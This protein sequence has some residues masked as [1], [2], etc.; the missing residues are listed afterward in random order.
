M[1]VTVTCVPTPASSSTRCETKR[2]VWPSR[3]SS[4]QYT[5]AGALGSTSPRH[6]R[7]WRRSDMQPPRRSMRKARYESARTS[8]PPSRSDE[9]SR[10]RGCELQ[11]YSERRFDQRPEKTK[12]VGRSRENPSSGRRPYL[13]ASSPSFFYRP[14]ANDCLVKPAGTWKIESSNVARRASVIVIVSVRPRASTVRVRIGMPVKPRSG[15][16]TPVI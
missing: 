7:P 15:L 11:G 16:P 1:S 13:V 3:T 8:G 9:V 2:T 6:R 4:N 14:G 12:A 5:T 10:F